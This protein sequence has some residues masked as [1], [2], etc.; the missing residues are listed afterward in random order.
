MKKF[1]FALFSLMLA[2]CMAS[3]G[4]DEVEPGGGSG[5]T[6]GT[7][8]DPVGT[9]TLSM[10][11]A[12]NGDTRLD[13]YIHID[14]DDNFEGDGWWYDSPIPYG[15]PQYVHFASVGQVKGLGNV[16]GIPA[17]GWARKIA[18]VPGEGVVAY[19]DGKFYRLYVQDYVYAAGSG[20]VIGAEIKYQKPFGGVDEAIKFD[21]KS[22]AIDSKGGAESV[23][24]TNSTIVPFTV[25]SSEEWCRV[26]TCSTHEYSWLVD[27]VHVACDENFSESAR[28]ATITVTTQTKKQTTFTVTQ[29]GA[30]PYVNITNSI[31]IDA[32]EGEHFVV[33]NTNQSKEDLILNTSSS[34]LKANVVESTYEAPA[35]QKK[36]R[37]IG[38]KEASETRAA[39]YPVM[40]YKLRITAEGNPNT[41]ERKGTISIS[42]KDRKVSAELTVI[43][44]PLRFDVKKHVYL[45]RNGS[46]QTVIIETNS[47]SWEAESSASWLHFNKNGKQ[48]TIRADE[49]TGTNLDRT[50]TISF[51]GL[52]PKITVTQNKYAVGDTYQEGKITGTVYLMSDS[53]RL[54]RSEKLG[55]AAWSTENV[56]TGANSETDGMYNTNIIKSISGY[57]KLYPAFALVEELNVDGAT[58]WY[59]PAKTEIPISDGGSYVWTSTEYSANYAYYGYA[60]TDIPNYYDY[61]N[62]SESGMSV[63]GV[64]RF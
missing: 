3:C 42:T 10:R 63:Y 34:W 24:C 12:S 53:I 17:N 62:K 61:R 48:I 37:W 32:G 59:L 44:E 60:Y 64:H 52:S 58:G 57:K 50:A 55:K 30:E 11:N 23:L 16:T 29:A 47:A 26:Q 8:A 4:E 5:T 46:A 49:Y 51:K 41:T 56:L 33:F 21:R 40:E 35:E 13:S 9:I 15:S 2:F 39:E 25:T 22:I 14:K 43:Q 18:V 36:V 6:G 31:T 54:I 1:C 20:G 28:T 27:G 38:N 45:D 19:A 7:V